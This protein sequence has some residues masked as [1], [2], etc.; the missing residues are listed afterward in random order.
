MLGGASYDLI[1]LITERQFIQHLLHALFGNALK[2]T[3]NGRFTGVN[4]FLP[5]HCDSG[6]PAKS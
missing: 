5:H 4:P 1:W 2:G 3:R 6:K